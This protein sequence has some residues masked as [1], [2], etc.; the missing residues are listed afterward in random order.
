MDYF[1]SKK[2]AYEYIKASQQDVICMFKE[3]FAWNIEFVAVNDTFVDRNISY[4]V[5][6]LKIG[7]IVCQGEDTAIA[8]S[9][10]SFCQVPY[11]MSKK[12]IYKIEWTGEVEGVSHYLYGQPTYDLEEYVRLIKQVY[13]VF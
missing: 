3:P 8:D 13:D 5:T 9:V 1:Y 7:E 6:D 4:K 2:P 12:T 11:T 10:T